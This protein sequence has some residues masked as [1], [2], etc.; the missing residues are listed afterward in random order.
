MTDGFWKLGDSA[1]PGAQGRMKESQPQP[2]RQQG[3]SHALVFSTRIGAAS[4]TGFVVERQPTLP[5]SDDMAV[6]WVH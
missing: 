3:L 6:K 1:T 5:E 2:D 4:M